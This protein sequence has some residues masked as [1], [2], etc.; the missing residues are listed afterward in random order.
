ME[1]PWKLNKEVYAEMHCEPQSNYFKVLFH[2]TGTFNKWIPNAEVHK[3]ARDE[4]SSSNY[5]TEVFLVS[6]SI[7][8]TFLENPLAY[9]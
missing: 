2:L 5:S 7:F 3:I 1:L 8:W 9:T 4:Y 6:L